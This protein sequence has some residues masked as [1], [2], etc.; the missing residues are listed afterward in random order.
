MFLY[1]EQGSSFEI[2]YNKSMN[3][4]GG[5]NFQDALSQG[6]QQLDE[7][8]KMLSQQEKLVRELKAAKDKEFQE[9]DRLQAASALAHIFERADS[10]TA[11]W[12]TNPTYIP[13]WINEEKSQGYLRWEIV[14][15]GIPEDYFLFLTRPP[16]HAASVYMGHKDTQ[17]L[18]KIESLADFAAAIALL[19]ANDQKDV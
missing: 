12:L 14:L 3:T 9:K 1:Q 18:E 15:P 6:K 17:H 13:S 19:K 10:E 11:T 5:F 2:P 4:H 8:M 7:E 16:Y